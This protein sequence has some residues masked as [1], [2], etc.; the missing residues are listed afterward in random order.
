MSQHIDNLVGSGIASQTAGSIHVEG[1]TKDF[2]TETGVEHVFGDVDFVVEPGNFVSLLGKSGSGKSTMLK[3]IS[4][5]LE[6]TAGSVHFE[7]ESGSGDVTIGHV[8]Q[9]PRLLPWKTAVGNIAYVHTRDPDYHEGVAKRWLDMVGLEDHYDKYPSQLSGGQRQRVGIA[10]AFSIDPEV[11]LMDE[12]FS[13][14]DEIT[15]EALRDELIEIWQEFN[16]TILF[17][18]HDINEAIELSDRILMLGKGRIYQDIDVPM[19]R[20]RDVASGAFLKFRDE[21]INRFYS[22]EDADGRR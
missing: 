7:T 16:K 20:P 18:T 21:A 17:V 6:A 10:R 22:L 13:N 5:V 8:F 11:L 12:P 1:L 2:D 4:G 15:A 14:L 9:S 3:I 19:G